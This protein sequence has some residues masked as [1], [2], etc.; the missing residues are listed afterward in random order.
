MSTSR[1]VLEKEA[2]KA[3]SADIYYDLLDTIET[4]TE[5][6]LQDIIDSN[7]NIDQ[8]ID[9]NSIAEDID[10]AFPAGGPKPDVA[11]KR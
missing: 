2:L 9:L 7:N 8:P 1:D 3:A 10:A 5:Q 4:A 6:E 11:M